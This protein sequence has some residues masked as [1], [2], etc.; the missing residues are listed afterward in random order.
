MRKIYSILIT[1]ILLISTTSIVLADAGDDKGNHY[2]KDDD[3]KGDDDQNETDDQDEN[4]TEDD[5]DD[6]TEKEIEIVNNTFGAEIR[7][8]QLEKAL[9]KNIL[10]GE[11]AVQVLIGLNFTTNELESILTK[12][13]ALLEE[14]RAANTSS[15]ASVEIFVFLKNESKNFTTQFRETIRGL[16]NDTSLS[17]LRVRIKE[18]LNAS[19]QL[20]DYNKRIINLIRTFNGNQLYRLYGLIG[21]ANSPFVNEYLNGTLPLNETKLQL[22][23]IINE[24]TKEK[25]YEIFLEIKGENIRRQIHAQDAIENMGKGNGH[26]KQ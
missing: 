4:E 16:L 12:M 19:G 21:E 13:K 2:G 24:M 8:L 7:L 5:V 22:C 3:F 20:D 1:L 10:K 6:K 26:G 14:V 23:K 17:E 25:K 18:M 15:N 9:L 11:M